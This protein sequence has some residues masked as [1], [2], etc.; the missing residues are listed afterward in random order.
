V[1]PCTSIILYEL[2]S[3][4]ARDS[5]I[6]TRFVV[7]AVHKGSSKKFCGGFALVAPRAEFVRGNMPK[8]VALIVLILVT[9]TE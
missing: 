1:A 6:H 7:H 3:I 5:G 2:I 8:L 9:P 4:P